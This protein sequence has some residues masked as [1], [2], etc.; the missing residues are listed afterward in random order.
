MYAFILILITLNDANQLYNKA[1]NIYNSGHLEDA[2]VYLQ[3]AITLNPK[4]PHPYALLSEIYLYSPILKNL[5]LALDLAK[6]SFYLL[7]NTNYLISQSQK[8]I[9]YRALILSYYLNGYIEE[10]TRLSQKA[11]SV[12]SESIVLRRLSAFLTNHQKTFYPIKAILAKTCTVKPPETQDLNSLIRSH[13]HN[14]NDT[15][16]MYKI[17]YLYY[18][19]NNSLMSMTYRYELLDISSNHFEALKLLALNYLCGNANRNLIKAIKILKGLYASRKECE[20]SSQLATTYYLSNNYPSVLLIAEKMH[21]SCP[22]N[23]LLNMVLH[24]TLLIMLGQGYERTN[25]TSNPS[26]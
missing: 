17:S 4:L 3:K 7:K 6:K 22:D 21:S 11:N 19:K 14:P 2:V 20:I 24:N 26:F 18:Y 16:I 23:N 1:W 10:A 8:C 9:V 12:C 15:T 5:N 13:K 25:P